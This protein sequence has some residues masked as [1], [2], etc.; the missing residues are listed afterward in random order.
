MKYITLLLIFFVSTTHNAVAQGQES[1]IQALF[2]MKFVDNIIWP[3]D[4]KNIVIGIYGKSEVFTEI[5]TKLKSK[6]PNGII[7][8]MITLQEATSCDVIFVA[9]HVTGNLPAINLAING[10]S[11]LT[12]TDADLS[13]KGS[14]ISFIEDDGRLSFIINKG[15]IDYLGLKISNSLLTLGKQA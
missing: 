1:K 5:D 2:I 9:K 3:Q 7:V 14:A 8:K 4:R 13:K 15:I 6:N 12:I 11:I 10:K